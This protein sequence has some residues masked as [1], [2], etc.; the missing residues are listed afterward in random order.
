MNHPEEDSSIWDPIVA[1]VAV[2][3]VVGLGVVCA[4]YFMTLPLAPR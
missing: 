4:R 1:I 2:G 3:V